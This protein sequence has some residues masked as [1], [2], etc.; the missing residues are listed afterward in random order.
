MCESGEGEEAEGVYT[1]TKKFQ[2]DVDKERQSIDLYSSATIDWHAGIYPDDQTVL[3][4]ALM[5]VRAAND[6]EIEYS[7]DRDGWVIYQSVTVGYTE[8]E[9]REPIEERREKA[10]IPSWDADEVEPD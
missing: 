1:V 9:C 2:V 7:S 6:I 8:G 10:F 3:T 5:H 4:V